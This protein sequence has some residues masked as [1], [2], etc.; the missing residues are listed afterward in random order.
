[1]RREFESELLRKCSRPGPIVDFFHLY[2]PVSSEEHLTLVLR[3]KAR[4]KGRFPQIAL[5]QS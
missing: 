4:N 2:I 1:M 3:L 5:L